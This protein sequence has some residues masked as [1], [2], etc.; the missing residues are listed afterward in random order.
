MGDPFYSQKKDDLIKK[1]QDQVDASNKE[2]ADGEANGFPPP[3]HCAKCNMPVKFLHILP[4]IR[5]T[6]LCPRCYHES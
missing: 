2:K 5:K 1:L 6:G 3:Y 4:S